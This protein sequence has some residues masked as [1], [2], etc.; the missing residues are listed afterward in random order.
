MRMRVGYSRVSRKDQRLESQC[1]ALLGDGCERVF[2]EKISSSQAE[3]AKFREAFDYCRKDDVLVVV[4]ENKPRAGQRAIG[5]LAWSPCHPED[6]R[7]REKRHGAVDEAFAPL[8]H[9]PGAHY[10]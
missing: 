10:G 3:R 7:H 1:D 8:D 9:E 2:E 5:L 6:V 4:W